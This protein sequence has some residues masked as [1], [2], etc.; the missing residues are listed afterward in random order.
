MMSDFQAI[1]DRVEIEALRGELTDAAMM[2]DPYGVAE[3]L[4]ARGIHARRFT[5]RDHDQTLMTVP[6]DRAPDRLPDTL[7][8]A[9]RITE[10]N[11]SDVLFRDGT[12]ASEDEGDQHFG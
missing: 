8:A 9:K 10:S 11:L 5:I 1:A 4:A 7:L 2:R 12:D 3:P 6:F